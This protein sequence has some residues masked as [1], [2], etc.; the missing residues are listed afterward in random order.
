M[1]P[2][3]AVVI[4]LSALAAC[5]RGPAPAVRAARV[6]RGSYLVNGVGRCF[7]CHSPQTSSDPSTPRPETLGAGDTLDKSAPVVAPN[8]TQ[9]AETGLGRWSDAEIVRAVREGVGRDGRRLRGDH[10]ANYYSVL[11]DGDAAAVVA[12]LRSL[13]PIRNP[14]PRSAPSTRDGETVQ[15]VVRPMATLPDTP[16]GRGAYLVQLAECAGCHTTTTAAGKPHRKML[17]GGGRRFVE[18]RL[19]YGYELSPDP[20]FANAPDPPLQKGER[21]VTSANLTSDPSGIS[22]YTPELFV[23]TIR[24]GKVGGVRRLS[25]AMPWVYFRTLTDQDLRDIF[26]YLRS[27]RPVRHAVDNSDTPTLCRICGRRHGLG[28]SNVAE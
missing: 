4:C 18:T 22:Y 21:I 5:N 11:S 12:Y 10:P 8:L 13:R 27:V 16:E 14:L 19:G 6:A 23:R 20:A 17:F 2:G 26:A 9:D 25:S 1:R 28:D 3:I 7:W 24:S 15:P